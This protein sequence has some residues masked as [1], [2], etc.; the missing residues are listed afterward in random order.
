MAAEDLEFVGQVPRP[1]DL[2]KKGLSKYT[3]DPLKSFI[4]FL[5]RAAPVAYGS[6]QARVEWIC[7]CRPT[8][9]P[10]PLP[11]QRGILNPLSEARD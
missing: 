11:Q 6:S 9:Q 2:Q 8:L 3:K 7:S 4:V 1:K 5:F 10:Q